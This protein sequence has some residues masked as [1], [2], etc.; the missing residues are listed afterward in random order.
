MGP[1]RHRLPCFCFVRTLHNVHQTMPSTVGFLH[2][3]Y[4]FYPV[5][6]DKRLGSRLPSPMATHSSSH[7]APRRPCARSSFVP[8]ALSL[9][10]WFDHPLSDVDFPDS[11]TTLTLSRDF[12]RSIDAVR[13]P[14]RLARLTFG[15]FFSRSIEVAARNWPPTL[16]YL[17]LGDC[18]NL[19]VVGVVLPRGLEEVRRE[20]RTEQNR[21]N[22]RARP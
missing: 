8:Q 19:P 9:G 12:N 1:V 2:L 4:V 11:L 14:R 18:Y 7:D 22:R 16:R 5:T 15:F 13:W 10:S 21:P 3:V 6:R 20:N 17:Q